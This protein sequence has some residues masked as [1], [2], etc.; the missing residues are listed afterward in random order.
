MGD[1]KKADGFISITDLWRLCLT[2]WKWFVVSVA[3]CLFFAVNYLLTT[4]YLYKRE[5]AIMVRD[6]SAS[7]GNSNRGTKE[8]SEID[9]VNQKGSVSNVVRHLSSLDVMMEVAHRCRIHSQ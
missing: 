6:E 2:H 4:P 1:N 5:A 9:F 7:Q 3:V 8:F